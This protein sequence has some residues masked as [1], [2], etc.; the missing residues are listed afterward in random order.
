MGA[1]PRGLFDAVVAT[2]Q[3]LLGCYTVFYSPILLKVFYSPILLIAEAIAPLEHVLHCSL[4]G[5]N[6]GGCSLAQG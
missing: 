5:G 1:I 2:I 3:E 4:W 6:P